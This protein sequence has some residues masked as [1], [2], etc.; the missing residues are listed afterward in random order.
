M[1]YESRIMNIKFKNIFSIII[2]LVGFFFASPELFSGGGFVN[3]AEAA[4]EI[5]RT[6][7]PSGQ[8]G[9]V[10]GDT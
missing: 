2:F 10:G 4:T 3:I 8:G 1:N 5:I 9:E 7:K 6:I